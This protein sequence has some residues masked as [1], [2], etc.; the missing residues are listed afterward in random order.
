M[1]GDLDERA[2]NTGVPGAELYK[3]DGASAVKISIADEY[4]DD[5]VN[6]VCA[7]AFMKNAQFAGNGPNAGAYANMFIGSLNAKV[8]AVTGNNPNLQ[9]LPFA[10]EPVGAAS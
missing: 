3:Y 10:P 4:I 9:R 8:T 5:L 2:A 7:R 1:F 6:Y